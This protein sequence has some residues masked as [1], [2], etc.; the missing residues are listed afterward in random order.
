MQSI[1]QSQYLRNI[2][3]YFNRYLFDRRLEDNIILG[4]SY[5]LKTEG[6]FIHDK[7]D[8]LSQKIYHEILIDENLLN[9]KTEY[10]LAVL[11][12]QMVHLWQHS[13]GT[14]KAPRHYHNEEFVKK[15]QSAGLII[16]AGYSNEQSINPEGLFMEAAKTIIDNGDDLKL[17]KPRN[18][19]AQLGSNKN[20]K[21][22]KFSCPDC[23]A[24]V[25]GKSATF[26]ICG[27][28]KKPLELQE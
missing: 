16:K 24:N 10:W 21:K 2:Y 7:W 4:L 22:F 15:M 17:L 25:W 6:L 23:G 3:D 14:N 19:A 20:G 8:D 5:K 12:H 1:W 11:V 9:E 13:Y 18:V 27:T 28:C 26:V